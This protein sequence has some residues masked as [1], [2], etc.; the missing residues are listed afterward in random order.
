[1][2]RHWFLSVA[3]ESRPILWLVVSFIW[4][5]S[6]I[7]CKHRCALATTQSQSLL[8]LRRGDATANGR[9]DIEKMNE[10]FKPLEEAIKQHNFMNYPGQVCWSGNPSVCHI[11]C[12]MLD[13]DWTDGEVPGMTYG[14]S[15]NGWID[16]EVFYGWLTD[17]FLK[18]AVGSQPL[19]LL[20]DGQVHNI[21]QQQF[22]LPKNMMSLC[23]AYHHTPHMSH[24]LSTCVFG[25]LKWNWGDMRHKFMQQHPGQIVIKYQFLP[26]STRP[27]WSQWFLQLL[28]PGLKNV[29]SIWCNCHTH[30]KYS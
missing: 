17:H 9:L 24:N 16:S 8:S 28:S 27:G 10:Y 19:L 18:H 22:A 14:L 2:V 29:V 11:W 20:L 7:L 1:M 25:P 21:T 13:Y 15:S 4:N 3:T 23:S 30:T 12:K 5:C 6:Q 26:S